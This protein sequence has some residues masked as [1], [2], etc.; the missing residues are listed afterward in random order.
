M[1]F[2]L[3]WAIRGLVTLSLKWEFA[4]SS[5]VIVR[6][7]LMICVYICIRFLYCVGFI[8]LGMILFLGLF[9]G[10]WSLSS[11][12]RGLESRRW[13][14]LVIFNN[15]I[16][17]VFNRLD[18]VDCVLCVVSVLN[19]FGV[20]MNGKL[21]NRE[22]FVVIVS[23]KFGGEFSFVS[24]A[25]SLMVSLSKW[26]SVFLVCMR[27]FLYCCLYLL[28]FCVSVIGMVF[29]RCVLLIFIMFFYASIFWCNVFCSIFN[30]G[31]SC[32]CILCVVVMDI[33]V[34]NVLLFDCDLL[35]WLFGWI[36]DL[37]ST[38]SSSTREFA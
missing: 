20:F 8:L 10:S 5:M 15:E 28:N 26:M 13:I 4:E 33:V 18:S 16:V 27:E 3:L 7:L 31:I 11:S 9:L 6:L 12:A 23:S 1:E 29:W 19:L 32:F 2:R 36:G 35:M 14:S 34:G 24:T 21:V 37:V 38:A 30:V 22:I 17:I 25:V